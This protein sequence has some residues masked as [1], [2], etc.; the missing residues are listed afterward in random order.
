VTTSVTS[1]PRW[2]DAIR[3]GI[4]RWLDCNATGL[5]QSVDDFADDPQA[6]FLGRSFS[7]EESTREGSYLHE[8]RLIRGIE[9][10]Q[11]DVLFRPRI[12]A[13]GRDALHSPGLIGQPGS[14]GSVFQ[15]HSTRVTTG[16][17]SQIGGI[18]AGGQ[19]N[20]QTVSQVLAAQERSEVLRD[21]DR[22]RELVNQVPVTEQQRQDLQTAVEGVREAASGDEPLKQRIR[23][24]AGKV[25]VAGATALVTEEGRQ[26]AQV[27]AHVLSLA[28]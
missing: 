6:S 20:I 11:S 7:R 5:I 26:I 14:G 2:L 9:T 13:A 8:Q 16:S 25:V 18:Q 22:M 19:G 1:G 23:D 12:T 15:D 17:H 27:V 4:L 3:R 21:V 24:A 10:D 28:Q